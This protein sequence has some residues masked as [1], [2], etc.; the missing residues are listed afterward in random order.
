DKML[1]LKIRISEQDGEPYQDSLA[2]ELE[3]VRAGL[4]RQYVDGVVSGAFRTIMDL[5]NV[6]PGEIVVSIGAHGDIGSCAVI[7]DHLASVV[8][9]LLLRQSELPEEQEL[10]AMLDWRKPGHSWW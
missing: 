1:R 6:P 5:S 3:T 7:F 8:T 10:F 2:R 4:P 9:R